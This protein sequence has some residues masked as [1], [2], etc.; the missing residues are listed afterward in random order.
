MVYCSRSRH[1]SACGKIINREANRLAG[2]GWDDE[3]HRNTI[4]FPCSGRDKNGAYYQFLF[5]RK[6]SGDVFSLE[7]KWRPDSERSRWPI[8]S[9]V[10][11]SKTNT[12]AEEQ[13]PEIGSNELSRTIISFI[14][15]LH[16]IKALCLTDHSCTCYVTICSV[17]IR[18]QNFV[19]LFVYIRLHYSDAFYF[20]SY[21]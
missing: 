20:I 8:V 21:Y 18:N 16:N 3:T 1:N 6:C 11:S 12:T 9:P 17:Q 5:D 15:S 2:E 19:Y 4:T 14:R 10:I 13:T 7:G